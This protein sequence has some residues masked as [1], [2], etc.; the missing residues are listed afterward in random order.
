MMITNNFKNYD[1]SKEV[2]Y[3]N[4]GYFS[5]FEENKNTPKQILRLIMN[6]KTGE[7]YILNYERNDEGKINS[8]NQKVSKRIDLAENF[9]EELSNTDNTVYKWLL[10]TLENTINTEL[11]DTERVINSLVVSLKDNIEKGSG[12]LRIDK[13][14]EELPHG[15]NIERFLINLFNKNDEEEYEEIKEEVRNGLDKRINQG[16]Y[17]KKLSQIIKREYGLQESDLTHEPLLFDK[18]KNVYTEIEIPE[19]KHLMN[20]VLETPNLIHDDDINEALGYTDET[21]PKNYEYIQFKNCLYDITNDKII[22]D[23]SLSVYPYINIDLNLYRGEEFEKH[24]KDIEQKHYEKIYDE[25]KQ[26]THKNEKGEVTK[27]GYQD[28]L[29]RY[30]CKWLID[31]YL[32]SSLVDE[33]NIDNL[34]LNERI[35]GVLELIGYSLVAGNPKQIIPCFIGASGGGKS[36]LTKIITAMVEKNKENGKYVSNVGVKDISET[37]NNCVSLINSIINFSHDAT[38]S[39]VKDISI[40]KQIKGNDPII[41]DRKYKEPV[42]LYGKDSPLCFIV[43]NKMVK[44]RGRDESINSALVL[45]NFYKTY[46]STDEQIEELEDLII[47]DDDELEYLLCKSIQAYQNM[48][49]NGTF[50]FKT[51]QRLEEEMFRSTYPIAYIIKKYL[52]FDETL[53]A[54]AAA[55]YEN[56]EDEQYSLGDYYNYM[57]RKE[58]NTLIHT[59][60]K[61]ENLDVGYELG[62]NEIKPKWLIENVRK[63]FDLDEE[64]KTVTKKIDGKPTRVYMG[65]T[66]NDKGSELVKK[67]GL[68]E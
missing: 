45:V 5:I 57:T 68:D 3:S 24:F 42:T 50:V 59:V 1:I 47:N 66:Y 22:K 37:K 52:Y 51:K 53:D 29:T 20:N 12:E 58:L 61:I 35:Q 8:Q 7:T 60:S 39:T 43:A 9:Y 34:N 31:Y 62:S 17:R 16:Y 2:Q 49:K 63:A 4:E 38:Q 55:I 56:Y 36:L 11:Q 15:S 46:R 14:R 33:N 6:V 40:W 54:K 48:T 44:F 21:I 13:F 23:K 27:K 25:L 67:Y 41:I 18:E 10:S 32:K 65:L 19:L 28:I 26:S 64:Y 30:H